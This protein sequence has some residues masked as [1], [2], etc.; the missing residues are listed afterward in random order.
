MRTLPKELV[1]EGQTW[2]LM[3]PGLYMRN[4]IG[5]VTAPDGTV[6]EVSGSLN[7]LSVY[8]ETPWEHPSP[9]QPEPSELRGATSRPIL[10]K[11]MYVL[12]PGVTIAKLAAALMELPDVEEDVRLPDNNAKGS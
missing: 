11:A 4:H 10:G 9:P 7:G 8:L 2:K 6:F 3:E 12:S 5:E 1:V